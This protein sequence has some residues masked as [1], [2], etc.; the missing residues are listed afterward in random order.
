MNILL[1]SWWD[2]EVP[3]YIGIGNPGR[4]A[5]WR[6]RNPHCYAK[7]KSAESKGTFRIQVEVTGLTWEQA[8]D[9]ERKRISE[10][11]MICNETGTLT[12]YAEG[13]NGGNTQ[14]GWNDQRREEFICK[15][16][17][18]NSGRPKSSYGGAQGLIWITDGV[19]SDRIPANSK[20]PNGWSKGRPP[21]QSPFVWI[22]NGKENWQ[23]PV[24]DPIPLPLGFFPGVTKSH[25]RGKP[26]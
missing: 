13:G 25:Y 15:M 10:I 7:R 8:W 14:L 1:Y 23:F 3:F 26:L 20:I 17:E 24:S 6:K 9:L 22:T 18:V 16:K 2:G 12:N 21:F 5:E 11:G 19:N 4:E